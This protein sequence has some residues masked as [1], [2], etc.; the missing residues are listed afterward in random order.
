MA[1]ALR[2]PGEPGHDDGAP[3]TLPAPGDPGEAVEAGW[4][5]LVCVLGS[6]QVTRRGTP[7]ALRGGG[8]TEALLCKLALHPEGT[9]P[10]DALLAALWPD[11]DPAL[12]GQSLNSLV[13]GLHRLLG[14]AIGG[15]AVVLHANGGYRLNREAGVGTDLACFDALAAAGD[16]Y[17]RAGDPAAAAAAR[18][19]AVRL[20][21]GDLSAGTDVHAVVERER[22]LALYLTMLTRL[23]DYHFGEGA[24]AACLDYALRLLA[25]D[26][27][28]EDAHRLVMRCYVRRGERGQ[29]LRQ[30]RL[31][32]DVLRAE[33]DALPEPATTTLFDQVRLDPDSI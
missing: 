20:Y 21:R 1:M 17:E 25:S 22:L 26:P 4:P 16:Q 33:F 6:F 31:C 12:A 19:R 9:L 2:L 15:A 29:A 5:I 24:Y 10:R 11:R 18:C 32:Q 14:E 27:C 3:R 30:Y 13:Y 8:K 28:R 23:A 7:V